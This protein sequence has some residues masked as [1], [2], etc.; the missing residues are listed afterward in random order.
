MPLQVPWNRLIRFVAE[1][2]GNVHYGEP[3]LP[4]DQHDVGRLS[5]MS[6]FLAKTISG[7]PLDGTCIVTEQQLTV[8]K[9]LCPLSKDTVPAVRCIGGNY[10]TH[11]ELPPCWVPS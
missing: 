11:C 2:D 4:E 10:K 7:N 8:K 9:L 1:E 6:P 3:I 5:A